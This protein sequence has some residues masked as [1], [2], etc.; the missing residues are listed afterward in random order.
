[1]T[2][3]RFASLLLACL[4]GLPLP[5]VHAQEVPEFRHWLADDTLIVAK[6]FGENL[7]AISALDGRDTIYHAPRSL[8]EQLPPPFSGQR[9]AATDDSGRQGVISREGDL[10]YFAEGMARPLRLTNDPAEEQNPTFSPDGRQLAFT[11]AGNLFVLELATGEER[12]LT[13]SGNEDIYNGYASWIYYEEV[14]GRSSRHKAFYWSPDSRFIAFL[15]FDDRPVPRF[16]IFHHEQGDSVH[17]WLEW[18]RY[19]KAGDPLPGVSL[20]IAQVPS[21]ELM[22]VPVNDQGPYLARVRW[23]PDGKNLFFQQMNRAQDTLGLYRFD[24]A[25]GE[26][27]LLFEESRATWV[28]F[29]RMLFLEGSDRFIWTSDRSGWSNLFLYDRDGTLVH[30]LTSADWEVDQ[31]K[32]VDEIRGH[33]YFEGSGQ[34]KTDLHL[35]RVQLDG[36]SLRQLTQGPGHH[37]TFLSPDFEYFAD[38]HSRHDDPGSLALCTIA[39][40]RLHS[41]GEAAMDP[42]RQAGIFVEHFSIPLSDG[43]KLPAYWVLPPG[44]DPTQPHPL[45]FHIYGGPGFEAVHDRFRD[46]SRDPLVQ[47]GVI[48]FTVDHRGSG[49]FGRAGMDELHRRLGHWEIHDYVEAVNWLQDNPFIDPSRIGIRGS[50]YGG[51]LAALALAK[52]PEHFTHAVARAPVTDWRLYDN[53]YTERYMD[54]PQDNAE[55]YED[56]SVIAGA[57][58]ISGKLLLVHGTVDDNVHLQHSMQLASRL[59]ELGK[60]F[61]LMIYPGGRHGWGG[62]KRRHANTLEENFFLDHFFGN[63]GG[64]Q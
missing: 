48:R 42:N 61:D 38:R 52:A 30:Q 28:T 9:L 46:F 17:G 22:P 47:Q 39:G 8:A 2:I 13:D 41:L 14:L 3:L 11:R 35:F 55:G 60:T 24:P 31:I 54:L 43:R 34:T 5:V 53:V 15:R 36:D 45:V 21:G 50:S 37:R 12:A 27:R 44:F 4:L 40:E 56:A 18:T 19:P 16:P 26:L 7:Y 32:G 10:F 63:L 64:A 29:G 33:V 57:D 51:Y 59:Q 58:R 20:H 62:A 25:A 23:A 6:G 1:M 49:K